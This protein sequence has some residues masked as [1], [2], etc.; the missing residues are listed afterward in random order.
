MCASSIPGVLPLCKNY[1]FP[2]LLPNTYI[3]G[4]KLRKKQLRKLGACRQLSETVPV[5]KRGDKSAAKRKEKERKREDY[6]H[7]SF[8]LQVSSLCFR[9][10][11]FFMSWKVCS[12]PAFCKSISAFPQRLSASVS[13]AF[14]QFTMFHAISSSFYLLVVCDQWS[15]MLLILL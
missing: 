9:S 12:D 1:L 3:S 14:Q 10:L 13:V 5:I 8:W 7:A 6:R 11:R 15:L 4:G 2:Y